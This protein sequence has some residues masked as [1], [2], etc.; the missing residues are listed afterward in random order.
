M[1]EILILNPATGEKLGVKKSWS[2]KQILDA[3]KKAHEKAKFFKNTTIEQRIKEIKKIKRYIIENIEEI[4]EWISKDLGK[5]K[6]EVL[7]MEIYP[8]LDC[9]SYYEKNAERILKDKKVR[10]P[11]SLMGKKSYI[12]YE[13]LGVVL[14]I[15]PWNYPFNLSLIPII[16][17]VIAG[18][19]VIYKPSELATY[20][21]MLIE[22]ILEKTGFEKDVVTIVYGKSS[23]IGDAL[24]EGKPDKIF[25]IMIVVLF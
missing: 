14:V 5:I 1:S 20:T 2:K 8:V 12:F 25:F 19:T 3:Y 15:A 21:G 24:I 17:A 9:I 18:N 23:E 22:D 16:S 13:P 4:V 7:L 11:I 6:S 10:N